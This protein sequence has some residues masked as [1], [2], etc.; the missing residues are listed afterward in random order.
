MSSR[1]SPVA[2]MLSRVMAK[3]RAAGAICLDRSGFTIA[4]C[5][6][7]LPPQTA[8][9]TGVSEKCGL[10]EADSKQSPTITVETNKRTLSIC[11][12]GDLVVA[13]ARK[14]TEH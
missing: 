12:R 2:E 4:R 11:S 6:E 5:G 14:S 13:L 1:P 7:S 10:L 3:E 9:I 8:H